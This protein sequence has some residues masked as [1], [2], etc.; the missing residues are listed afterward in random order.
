M[1]TM[2]VLGGLGPQATVDFEARVH[3]VAQG[4]V[5]QRGNGGYPPMVVGYHRRPPFVTDEGGI[6]PALP[7]RPDPELLDLARWL[8]TR[9]DFL[10]VPSNGAHAI[11]AEIERAAGRSVLSMVEATVAEV[12]RRGWA[13]VGLL[14]FGPFSVYAE[15]LKRLGLEAVEA[16]VE[17]RGKLN[18]V[19]VGV[20]EGRA[21][22]ATAMTAWEA[23]AG[24]RAAGVDGIIPGC[25]EIPLLL[26]EEAAGQDD[27]VN[28]AQLLAEAA[29]NFALEG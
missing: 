25:T 7:L 18:E 2:G 8:G 12:R 21:D 24:L 9:A 27:L 10:V 26:G 4:L 15:S 3:R 14:T 1:K 29:V 5:P 6:K 11:Q 17:T 23:V 20:M 22:V 19:I 16:G 28:P 13:K